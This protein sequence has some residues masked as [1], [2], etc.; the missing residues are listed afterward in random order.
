[1]FGY[2]GKILK[3]N[4]TE[5]LVEEIGLDLNLAQKFLGGAGLGSYSLCYPK[6]EM[7]QDFQV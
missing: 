7:S 3:I 2:M 6:F 1:M 5:S 4:L